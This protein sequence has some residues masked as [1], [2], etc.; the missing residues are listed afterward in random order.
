VTVQSTPQSVSDFVDWYVK[1]LK[2]GDAALGEQIKLKAKEAEAIVAKID[3]ARKPTDGDATPLPD[4]QQLLL[5]VNTQISEMLSKLVGRDPNIGNLEQ[6]YLL[7]GQVGTYA[8]IPKPVGD[9]LTPDH[10][11]QAS[12]IVAA[13]E[14]FKDDQELEGSELAKRAENRAAQGYAINLHFRRHVAGATYGSKGQKKED[15]L[16]KLR[17]QGKGMKPKDKK[18]L[19]VGHLKQALDKDVQRMKDVAKMKVTEEPWK[20]LKEEVKDDKAAETLRDQI[21]NRIVKGQDQI[22]SQPFN[23]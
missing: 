19:V 6:K 8:T 17:S 13:A 1:T 10:Q 3:A 12:I 9:K 7:E 22:A 21:A 11:P 4:Q 16:A 5:G 14:F 2:K 15:F 23:F 18:T 20:H